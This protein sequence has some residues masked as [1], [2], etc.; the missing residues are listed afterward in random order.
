M[1]MKSH[2]TPAL[3]SMLLGATLFISCEKDKEAVAP[4]PPST[5]TLLLEHHVDGEPLLFD[6]LKYTNEAGHGWSVNRLE[7][8]VSQIILHGAGG[9]P[10]DTIHGPYLGNGEGEHEPLTLDGFRRAASPGASASLGLLRP[11]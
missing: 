2:L 6:S 8:Y 9:T 10:D 7:Y 11:R 3:L 4:V 5:M 1:I